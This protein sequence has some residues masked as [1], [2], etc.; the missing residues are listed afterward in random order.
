MVRFAFIFILLGLIAVSFF[1]D[2][3]ASDEGKGICRSVY[4][5]SSSFLFDSDY[6][7]CILNETEQRELAL[8]TILK[9]EN[10]M[11]E[12]LSNLTNIQILAMAKVEQ[13]GRDKFVFIDKPLPPKR[14]SF[15]RGKEL[16][17]F[18]G[19]EYPS[20]LL[21][22]RFNN[23][24]FIRWRPSEEEPDPTEF[25]C[26]QFPEKQG[27]QFLQGNNWRRIDTPAKYILREVGEV[28]LYIEAA[29][30]T[31]TIG[32]TIRYEVHGFEV[33]DLMVKEYFNSLLKM[34]RDR[35]SSLLN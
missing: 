16:D 14:L 25:S 5:K 23:C 24:D 3:I 29:S 2:L 6:R 19:D 20:R 35:Y 30:V 15:S 34:Q 11:N 4:G 9:I 31:E 13:I 8:E 10:Q 32:S 28:T 27:W 33:T 26:Y 18:Y 1:D 22:I 17:P 7:S 12:A 21:K